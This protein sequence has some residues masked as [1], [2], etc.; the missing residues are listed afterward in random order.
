MGSLDKRIEALEKLYASGIAEERSAAERGRKELI[1][2]ANNG[3]LDAMA[4]IKRAPI[5]RLEWRYEVEKL[6]DRG[7][8]AIACYVAALAHTQHPDE[9]RGR[10]ILKEVEAER[11]IEE[12]PLWAM[13]YSLVDGLNRMREGEECEKRGA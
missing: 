3:A 13:I 9:E 8:F 2:K 12:S 4:N 7:P 6:K 11:G 5:N 1:H 10:E